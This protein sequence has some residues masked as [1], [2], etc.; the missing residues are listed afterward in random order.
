MSRMKSAMC[1]PTTS[2]ASLVRCFYR[3][4]SRGMPTAG[5]VSASA[6]MK[7]AGLEPASVGLSRYLLPSWSTARNAFWLPVSPGK[8]AG[9]TLCPD[10]FSEESN[11]G[12]T[13]YKTAVLPTELLKH[14]SFYHSLYRVASSF[15]LPS[16]LILPLFFSL[17]V[18]AGRLIATAGTLT[19]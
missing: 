2:P 17:A 13:V 16:R 15:P 7:A 11:P 18:S 4:S 14:T 9:H 19:K 3:D 5:I 12:Q 1:E 6:S 10:S 8:R